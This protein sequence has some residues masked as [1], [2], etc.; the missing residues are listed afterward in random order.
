MSKEILTDG[1]LKE[2]VARAF[3]MESSVYERGS[4]SSRR[5]TGRGWR[6]LQQPQ[7][8][9]VRSQKGTVSAGRGNGCG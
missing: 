1:L 7:K 3:E 9:G 6:S 8:A 4:M 5:N 2:A